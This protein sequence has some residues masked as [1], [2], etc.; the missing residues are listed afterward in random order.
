MPSL[1]VSIG[2][3]DRTL[4]RITAANDFLVGSA[5]DV[6][7]KKTLAETLTILASVAGPFWKCD[8]TIPQVV[9]GTPTFPLLITAKIYPSA[10]STT[11]FRLM[12]ADGVTAVLTG[13]TSN[14]RI[15]IGGTPTAS[16]KLEIF[17]SLGNI[18]FNENGAFITFTR[19]SVSHIKSSGA[20]SS[21]SFS[22]AGT[23]Y[24]LFITSSGDIAIGTSHMDG[25]HEA[26]GRLVVKGS[27]TDGTTNCLVLRDS[28]EGNCFHVDTN[29]VTYST[30][31][32][33]GGGGFIARTC[34]G[35]HASPTKAVAGSR[36]GAFIG[37]G[38][39][40][41][42]SGYINIAD[43]NFYANQD[44]TS[45]AGGSYATIR[46]C[47][48]GSVTRTER[49]RVGPTNF[50][51]GTYPTNYIE[52]ESD[53]TLKMTGTATVFEDMQFPISSAK[54]P[55]ANYP[56]WETFTTNTN[57][58]AFDVDEYIDCQASECPHSWREGTKLDFHLHITIKSLQN[59]GASQYA[60]FTIYVAYANQDNSV[61][62]EVAAISAEKTIPNGAA[63]LTNYYLDMGDVTPATT[64]G[65]QVKVRVKR[66]AATG[67]TEYA[68]SVFITQVGA[69]YEN[70][71]LGSR[72]ET[73]K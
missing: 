19:N 27:T 60:K 52:F 46:T 58:Y 63:A 24:R 14:G 41:T 61:W 40:E 45:T 32:G 1:T 55:A 31:D 35:T 23:D 36:I 72:T 66:I 48:D 30:V 2:D 64:I 29:G 25:T 70:D 51:Y 65:T 5:A 67:G 62:T 18:Q 22:T 21:I 10:D 13:D 71:T 34:A 44:L 43:I 20:S 57:E 7:V 4:G 3:R 28:A 15:G 59:S 50:Y 8:Q 11:A 39:Q 56:N 38:Y 42:T 68:S 12:K 49:M 17:G 53:G 73:G 9:T 69:H 54:V 26:I 37:G 47:A 33:A 16:N 6:M